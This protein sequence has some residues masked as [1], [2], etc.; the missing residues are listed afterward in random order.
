MI[1]VGTFQI[2]YSVLDGVGSIFVARE[3][4]LY[5]G[6]IEFSTKCSSALICIAIIYAGGGLAESLI[7][8]PV[9]AIFHVVTAHM[10]VIKKIGKLELG[11][12]WKRL[13]AILHEATPYAGYEF[14]RQLATR[15]D[16][17]FIGFMLGAASVGVYNVAYRVVFMLLFLPHFGSVAML[18][19][20]SRL[21]K[22]SQQELE[23]LY[24]SSLNIVVLIGLPIAAGIWLIAPALIDFIFGKE[25][26]E[27][28]Q[29]LR[30]LA[31]ILFFACFNSII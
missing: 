2:I 22:N 13:I 17:V 14:L 30:L 6:L 19:L 7:A 25:F 8:L 10:L 24:H 20:A 11:V 31:V 28:V 9:M 27:S 29:I 3:K 23:N 12:P 18:P 16:V 5:K 4:M 26:V 1:L 15:I 21:Y